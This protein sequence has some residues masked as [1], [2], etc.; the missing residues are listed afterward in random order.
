MELVA[1]IWPVVDG[2][3]GVVQRYFM[4]AYAIDAEDHVI[5][6]VLKALAPTDFVNA[7][8][9]KIGS[10]CG[11][12]LEDDSMA[13]A[14]PISVFHRH[15]HIIIENSYR[16]LENDYAKVQGIDMTSRPPRPVNVIPRFPNN[17]YTM[18]TVLI[19]TIDGRLIPQLSR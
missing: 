18:T 7:K 12:A 15:M 6:A 5:S 1:N 14:L 4:R 3:T 9:F 19:E 16:A 10:Q 11:I 13:G 17:P 8:G 2:G